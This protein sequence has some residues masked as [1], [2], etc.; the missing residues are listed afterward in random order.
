MTQLF[1]K[2]DRWG[3]KGSLWILVAMVFAIPLAWSA[4]GQIEIHNDVENWLPE[5]DPQSRILR[6]YAD[7]F[8]I[9]EQFLVSWDD[10][11]LADPRL[12]Q[13]ATALEGTADQDGIRRNGSPYF[14]SVTTP[15]ELV[16]RI[17]EQDIA[18]PVALE[19]TSGILIGSGPIKV[20]LTEAGRLQQASLERR[21]KQWG[22][23]ELNT[24]IEILEK[25]FELI[26]YLQLQQQTAAEEDP[27]SD[28]SP[29]PLQIDH[30]LQLT[31]KTL[32]VDSEARE[33]ALAMLAGLQ[34]VQSGERLVERTFFVGG[35][36]AA[37]FVELSEAGVADRGAAFD[38]L[39]QL[40]EKTG[41]APETL[42]MGG[43]PVAGYEL[44]KAVKKAGWDRSQPITHLHRRSVILTSMIVGVLLA[45]IMLRSARLTAAVEFT[46][47]YTV[48]LTVALVPTFGGSMNMVLVVMPTLLLVLTI[49][50]AI[51][52]V[53]YWK[54]AHLE[55]P[56]GAVVRAIK[57]A[58]TPC[59]LAAITT[60]IGLISLSTSPLAPV[61]DFGVFSAIGCL[62]L[63]VVV[64]YGLPALL[65]LMP[66]NRNTTIKDDSGVFVKLGSWIAGKHIAI[67][68][69][70]VTAF[71]G[72]SLGLQYFRTETKVI[73]Y[74]PDDSRL[75]QDYNFLEENL[76]GII[77][78][79]TVIR[80]DRASQRDFVSDDPDAEDDN[81][82]P[83]QKL[84]F[85]ERVEIVRRVQR[86]LEQ[87]PEISG[88]LSLADFLPETEKPEIDPSKGWAGRL[89]NK[90]YIE[91]SKRTKAGVEESDTAG[92]FR[93]VALESTDLAQ[94]GDEALN[95]EHDELWKI[96][97][98]VAIMS[99]MD[100]GQLTSE[101]DELVKS[102][103][104]FT[105]GAQ[106][107]VTGLVPLFLRTQ[108]AVLES[109]IYSFALAFGV[110]A[111]VMMILL[112]SIPAG[113]IT[114][115]P[116]LLPVGMVFGLISWAGLFVDIGTMITASVALGIAV[117]GTLH[118]LTWFRDGIEHGL[119]RKEAISKA[120][121]HCGP[122]MWQ[123]SAAVGIGLLMLYPAELLL[124]SRFGWLMASLIG[125]ALI[126]D[127]V[128][129]PALLA[130]PLGAIIER[131]IARRQQ[132]THPSKNVSKETSVPAIPQPHQLRAR[133]T[134]SRIP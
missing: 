124:I 61:K 93:V 70:C 28:E 106:H 1:E 66:P 125:T 126:A 118:L 128:F 12:N 32:H 115:L 5:D 129:L 7:L 113:L 21:I 41:I 103:L 64:L 62:V 130:G 27:D 67:T 24:E 72:C 9:E 132:A 111:I 95:S 89:A 86:K 49:S 60:A 17:T 107:R 10:S 73:R 11:S 119:T 63:V 98:Q 19:R 65:S 42:R 23:S 39:R 25:D 83:D 100:Y 75:V 29:E 8:P 94:T 122:A 76:A 51:H 71:V 22:Q 36:P 133:S 69:V 54:F 108:Q 92:S 38:E 110:I 56:E 102:E 44:N 101:I 34:D 121:G 20:E 84:T 4:I 58:R 15:E 112:R 30:D 109:L 87:H 48:F 52:V 3:N 96:T 50:A 127:V 99:D 47:I 74:F 91:R 97:A 85:L 80:F 90:K 104:K 43:R 59:S 18:L 105:P 46:A 131:G 31:W 57:M 79:N 53:N 13:L 6:W 88:T 81:I 2:R 116:N 40:A 37:L 35:V 33:S 55:E 82:S 26:D 14:V 45:F 68:L 120:L 134:D 78:V 16:Q 123:T 114:M 77:P 117:D